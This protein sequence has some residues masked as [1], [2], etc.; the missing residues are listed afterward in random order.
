MPSALS[1]RGAGTGAAPRDLWI[2]RGREGRG[3][4]SPA[5]RRSPGRAFA[6]SACSLLPLE[7]CC[8]CRSSSG[9]SSTLH[10]PERERRREGERRRVPQKG[11]A[12]ELQ[13]AFGRQQN[14]C[15]P[16]KRCKEP[17]SFFHRQFLPCP[18]FQRVKQAFGTSRPHPE[19]CRLCFIPHKTHPKYQKCRSKRIGMSMGAEQFCPREGGL[20]FSERRGQVKLGE[21]RKK[22]PFTAQINNT[23]EEGVK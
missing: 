12:P 10:Q 20:V 17:G 21:G 9:K 11:G 23:Q 5:V 15:K 3:C 19:S 13:A 14:C 8:C 6:P 18:S 4:L 22:S 7:S 1:K 16:G 2:S